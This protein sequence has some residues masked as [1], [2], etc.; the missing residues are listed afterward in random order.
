M[1]DKRAKALENLA[2]LCEDI[3]VVEYD[4][5]NG[6]YRYSCCNA[7]SHGPLAKGHDKDC[8]FEKIQ[9]AVLGLPD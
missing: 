5:P 8:W 2:K 4:D 1:T 9:M 3:H 6:P 7:P